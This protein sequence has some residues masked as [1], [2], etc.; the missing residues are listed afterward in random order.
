MIKEVEE[1]GE[2]LIWTDE[3]TASSKVM[4]TKLTIVVKR[5]MLEYP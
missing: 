1:D 2:R 4:Q 3:I 5:K